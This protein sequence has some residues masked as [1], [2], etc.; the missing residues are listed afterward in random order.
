MKKE[1]LKWLL[2]LILAIAGGIIAIKYGLEQVYVIMA[3]FFGI[4][5]LGFLVL[6]AVV[7]L[8]DY[9]LAKHPES[10][11]HAIKKRREQQKFAEEINKK[12]DK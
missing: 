8:V 12:F 2:I 11:S 6:F 10:F 4:A 9:Y 7:V 1:I 5:I 3:A